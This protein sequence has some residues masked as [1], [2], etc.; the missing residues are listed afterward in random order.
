MWA[1]RTG[2][3]TAID[4]HWIWQDGQRLT[5]DPLQI[6]AAMCRCPEAGPGREL[7]M[8]EVEKAHRSIC[9]MAWARATTP[10]PCST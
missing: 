10:S 6:G 1:P 2:R 5:K 8:V 7:D 9:S 4:T 3:V